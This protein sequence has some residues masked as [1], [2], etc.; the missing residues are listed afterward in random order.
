MLDLNL[1]YFPSSS[2]H[3]PAESQHLHLFGMQMNEHSGTSNSSVVN[4]ETSS[5]AGDEEYSNQPYHEHCFD[6]LKSGDNQVDEHEESYN[7]GSVVKPRFTTKE[8][9]PV[10]GSPR[11]MD[12]LVQQQVQQVKRSRRGPRSKSSQYRGVTFYRRTGRWESHIWSAYC[13][14]NF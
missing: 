8:L 14:C 7:Q 11:R 6:I 3:D 13:C 12:P 5:N 10:R 4:V 2:F 9:F 1:N